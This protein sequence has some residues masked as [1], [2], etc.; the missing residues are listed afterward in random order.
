LQVPLQLNYWAPC[1]ALFFVLLLHS[2]S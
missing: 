2:R 1:Y